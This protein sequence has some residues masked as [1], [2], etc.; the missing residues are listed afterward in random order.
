MVSGS[1]GHED[2]FPGMM[3]QKKRKKTWI[4]TLTYPRREGPSSGAPKTGTY[5]G[6]RGHV[7]ISDV[8]HMRRGPDVGRWRRG[9]RPG[10]RRHPTGC[11]VQRLR[12]VT[13]PDNKIPT[14][15]FCQ[16]VDASGGSL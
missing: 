7:T 10:A 1:S 14:P 3:G 2:R 16:A 13:C 4:R 9:S 11:A 8:V 5:Q 15:A 12:A 6:Y